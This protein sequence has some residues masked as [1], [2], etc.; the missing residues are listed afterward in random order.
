MCFYIIHTY[1]H[2]SDNRAGRSTPGKGDSRVY[3]LVNL[4]HLVCCLVN[5]CSPADNTAKGARQPGAL[6]GA[7]RHLSPESFRPLSAAGV[8]EP[9]VEEPAL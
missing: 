2:S 4:C 1:I 6:Q 3:C 5:S 7:L 9:G 8:G